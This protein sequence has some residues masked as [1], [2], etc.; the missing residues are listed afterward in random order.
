LIEWVSIGAVMMKITSN[1]SMTSIN[2]TIL[3]SELTCVLPEPLLKLPKA[4]TY[5][6]ACRRHRVLARFQCPDIVIGHHLLTGGQEGEQIIG[7]GIKLS[8]QQ[9]V[10][11][12]EEVIGQHSG[13]GHGQAQ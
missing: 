13:N 10:L 8:Q 6:S 9:T 1:T 4:M 12:G 3:I 5:S 2:G 7:K 11:A